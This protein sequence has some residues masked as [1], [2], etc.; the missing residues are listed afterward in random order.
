MGGIRRGDYV[1]YVTHLPTH[2][3]P[4]LAIGNGNAMQKI[5]SFDSEEYAGSFYKM[6]CEWLGLKEEDE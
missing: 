1:I 4:I 2:K 5:A 3:K 6:L